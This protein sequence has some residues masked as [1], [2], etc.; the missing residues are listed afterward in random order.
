MPHRKQDRRCTSSMRFLVVDDQN[1]ARKMLCQIVSNNPLWS[2][3][4]EAA[5]GLEAIARM[6]QKPDVVLMDVVMPVMDG[7]EATR[8]IKRLAPDTVVILT[9]A[10]QNREFRTRSLK[11]GA[12]GFVLKDDLTTDALRRILYA[13]EKRE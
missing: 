11:A 10:Y 7:L 8:Q 12:D 6:D 3:V 1:P 4:N 13:K 9:T 5:N 2:V